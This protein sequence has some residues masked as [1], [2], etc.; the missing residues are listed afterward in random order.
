MSSA[1]QPNLKTIRFE[2]ELLPN[3]AQLLDLASRL[4]PVPAE[5]Q[6]W[7]SKLTNSNGVD[8]ARTVMKHCE[9]LRAQLQPR[10]ER[11]TFELA[12][13]QRDTQPAQI[14]GAWL[15]ALDT[16]IQQASSRQTC[17]WIVEGLEPADDDD[18]GDGG[19]VKLRRL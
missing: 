10:G 12:R 14:Y 16:M 11:V 7:F 17:S 13:L 19:D 2:G 8:D 9:L 4:C 5:T 1:P 6:Q 3:W 15:Y 18:F